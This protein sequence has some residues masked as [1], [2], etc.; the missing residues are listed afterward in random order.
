MASPI[1]LQPCYGGRAAVLSL[2]I[3]LP[4]GEEEYTP[5]GASGTTLQSKISCSTPSS[6]Q[7]STSAPPL[8][9]Q[10]FVPQFFSFY[11]SF[12]L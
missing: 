12:S 3:Q 4:N 9:A 1:A 7:T 2:V 5:A 11:R 8:V 10:K 6:P